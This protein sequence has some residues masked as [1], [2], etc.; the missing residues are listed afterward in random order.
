MNGTKQR[1]RRTMKWKIFLMQYL[2]LRRL[3]YLLQLIPA[4][5]GEF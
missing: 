4:R 3:I 2:L 5:E 1:G